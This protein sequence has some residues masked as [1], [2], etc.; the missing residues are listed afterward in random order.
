M[1]GIL[2]MS[3]LDLRPFFLELVQQAAFFDVA[4]MHFMTAL[5]K[6]ACQGAHSNP[7]H[8][9]KMIRHKFLPNCKIC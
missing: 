8:P 4:S 1:N 7:T 2:R 3:D 5:Q 9:N 6:N